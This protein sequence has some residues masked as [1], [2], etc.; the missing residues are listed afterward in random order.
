MFD[1][2]TALLCGSGYSPTD[3]GWRI[4]DEENN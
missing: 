1:E 2:Q 3:D 4:I